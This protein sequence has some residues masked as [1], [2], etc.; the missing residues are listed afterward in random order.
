MDRVGQIRSFNRTV[1]RRIGALDAR[2]LGRDRSLGASR[3]LFEIGPEGSEIRELRSRLG[4]D[5][6]YMS[7]LLRTLEGEGLIRTGHAPDDARVRYVTLTAVGRE[8]VAALNRLS[9]DSAAS[10]L[11]PLSENQRVALTSAMAAVEKL[12]LASAVRLEVEDPTSRTAQ[13]C[14]ARYF[15]ELNARFDAGFDPALSLSP[16]AAEFT[17]PHG[18][19]VVASLNG[20]GVGCGALKC[21]ARYAE[22]KRM[23]VAASC[24]GLG[25]GR[26]I[27]HRLEDLAR[28]Q[29]IHVLRLETN[30]ALTEA[31]SLYKSSGYRE[32]GAFNEERYAHHWFEKTL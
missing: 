2:F 3:L 29:R 26:R 23:W 5:S 9:D 19:F 1:T 31:Q 24:R 18:Y 15:E 12:L 30:R 7:R 8:E 14:L 27:L 22:I 11:E 4:L 21:R 13:Q 10:I 28:E 6:G 17:P 32:V 16:S 20:E 25:L